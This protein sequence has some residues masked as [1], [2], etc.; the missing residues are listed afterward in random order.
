MN[1]GPR[2]HGMMI[3]IDDHGKGGHQISFWLKDGCLSLCMSVDSDTRARLANSYLWPDV[4]SFFLMQSFPSD[5]MPEA[6]L[7]ITP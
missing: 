6:R 1:Q 5:V 3:G 2:L 4:C 7:V